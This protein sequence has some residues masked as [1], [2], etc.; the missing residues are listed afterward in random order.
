MS[1]TKKRRQWED[2][3]HEDV[4]EG[5]WN[6]IGKVINEIYM[7]FYI[8]FVKCFKGSRKNH[9]TLLSNVNSFYSNYEI[10]RLIKS[11]FVA[12][13]VLKNPL[14]LLLPK[15]SLRDNFELFRK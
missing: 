5:L 2:C 7:I 10:Q 8:F 15:V 14:V 13:I 4:P 9:H 12:D 6:D 3:F 1:T 11:P